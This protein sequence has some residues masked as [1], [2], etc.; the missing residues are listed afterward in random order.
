MSTI[1][2][3]SPEVIQYYRNITSLICA[4]ARLQADVQIWT[5]QR[6][7]R[8]Y[9]RKTREAHRGQ[10]DSASDGQLE[11]HATAAPL[12]SATGGIHTLQ[13]PW[14]GHENPGESDETPQ[15][16]VIESQVAKQDKYKWLWN[17]IQVE[18]QDMNKYNI[19]KP[20]IQ[21]KPIISKID[22]ISL[23]HG[24]MRLVPRRNNPN[25]ETLIYIPL[26]H[27]TEIQ[28]YRIKVAKWS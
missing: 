23:S 26:S 7:S 10:K 27:A 11:I 20:E 14:P 19:I 18:R 4:I 6:H 25:K 1:T 17:R 21:I 28:A 22:C 3:L 15:A 24:P 2:E 16:S 9:K 5:V 8:V 12:W 13:A